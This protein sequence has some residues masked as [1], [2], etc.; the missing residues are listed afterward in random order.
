MRGG[1]KV[2]YQ[3]EFSGCRQQKLMKELMLNIHTHAMT[4]TTPSTHTETHVYTLTIYW[5]YTVLLTESYEMLRS[6]DS[7]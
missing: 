1:W 4:T 7:K 6:Q 3:L 2:K 5:K